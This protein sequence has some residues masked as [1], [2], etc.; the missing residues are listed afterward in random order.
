MSRKLDPGANL[1]SLRRNVWAVG[2]ELRGL[3]V[4]CGVR[5]I[6]RKRVVVR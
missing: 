5:Q 3:R 1:E 6:D 4:T 2:V